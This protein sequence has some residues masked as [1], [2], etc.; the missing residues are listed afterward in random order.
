MPK[1]FNTIQIKMTSAQ[2]QNLYRAYSDNID[3]DLIMGPKM[4][5]MSFINQPN[6][7]VMVDMKC[8]DCQFALR[9]NFALY[10]EYMKLEKSPF[11]LDTCPHCRKLQFVPLD[12]YNKLIDS[13]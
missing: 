2:K 7:E 10:A 5:Y 3:Q 12:I 8:L 13:I 11:P 1:F 4:S 9:V 6:L